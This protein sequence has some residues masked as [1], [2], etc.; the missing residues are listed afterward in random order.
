MIGPCR[1][2]RSVATFKQQSN[3]GE[4]RNALHFVLRWLLI[5]SEMGA[6]EENGEEDGW[7]EGV[8][9]G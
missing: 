2:D 8:D 1:V 5:G 6:G 9:K 3:A 4:P 7:S